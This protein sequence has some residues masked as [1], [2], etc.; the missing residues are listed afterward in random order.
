MDLFRDKKVK[1]IY[2]ALVQGTLKQKQGTIDSPI[3]GLSAK[4]EYRVIG[5]RK[6]F[7]IVEAMP[8]TGRKNQI[9]IHFKSIGHPVVGDTRFAFRKDYPL[10]AKRLLLHAEAIEFAHPVNHKTVRLDCGY[11]AD[12]EDFCKNILIRHENVIQ[13]M[14]GLS[15]YRLGRPGPLVETCL[16]AV[17]LCGFI[18]R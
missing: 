13:R 4:T 5:E 9:R 14:V 7:S 3:E 16:S 2:I 12:L 8:K 17:L 11:P 6:D 10:R 18:C 1:K 15:A